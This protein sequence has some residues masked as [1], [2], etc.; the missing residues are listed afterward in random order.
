MVFTDPV[1]NIVCDCSETSLDS[2][3]S[4]CCVSEWPAIDASV[5]VT[6][7]N[8]PNTSSI[9]QMKLHSTANFT[10]I[11]SQIIDT[12][13]NLQYLELTIGLEHLPLARMPRKLKH[14]N[15]G[16]N[17]IKSIDTG[18][19]QNAPDLEQLNL[20]YNQIDTL[21]DNGAF[22]GPKNLKH[23]ILYH[24]KLT[25]LKRDMFKTAQSLLSLDVGFNEITT[26]EDGTFDLP[27]IREILLNENKLKTLS[28]R[29]FYGAPNIQNVDLQKNVLEHIGKAFEMTTHLHQLQLSENHHLQDLNI[30]ELTSKL[31]E[32]ISLSVDATGLR[33][34]SSTTTATTA[35]TTPTAPATA[36]S[37]LHTLSI[38]QNHLSQMDFLKQLSAFPKLEKV[39]IDGNKFIRWDDADVRNIKKFFPNI[40]LIVTK[41]NA[42]D[43]RWVESTLIPVFQTNNIFCSNIKYLNTYIEGFTNNIDGQVIDGTECI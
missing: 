11:P 1:S 3:A 7:Q 19:I 38:S 42:W 22:S 35:T 39:F 43:R 18:A 13:A 6:F 29:I 26:I 30:I 8:V 21:A 4:A 20:Q 33:S 5:R 37:P 16:D 2:D 34:L 31:P 23:L 17:R 10:G 32:L 40:E 25:I 27:N 36:H 15:L 12:F 14:L 24:N 9:I 41:T 28:D